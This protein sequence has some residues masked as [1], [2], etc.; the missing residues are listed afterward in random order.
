MTWYAVQMKS[1]YDRPNQYQALKDVLTSSYGL[2]EDDI[3]ISGGGVKKNI[4]MG[5]VF[6]RTDESKQ[7]LWEKLS[8]ERQIDSDIG[9]I[10]IPDD[11]MV[12]LMSEAYPE[13]PI[14]EISVLDV[15]EVD[16]TIYKRMFGIVVGIRDDGLYEI[17]IRMFSRTQ[18]IL[19]N[20]Q[21]FH[22]VRSLFEIW[23]FPKRQK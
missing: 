2:S 15:V 12:G 3:W 14:E 10:E 18:F 1:S 16:D 4:Y 8:K 11:Q 20:Q 19:L 9:I 5:Y 7:A 17:G 22:K 23:K 13:K 21:Q 6:I